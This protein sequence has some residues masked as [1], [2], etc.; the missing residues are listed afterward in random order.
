V[1]IV[2]YNNIVVNSFFVFCSKSLSDGEI[3]I[4]GAPEDSG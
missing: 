4:V 2:A 3:F 1:C